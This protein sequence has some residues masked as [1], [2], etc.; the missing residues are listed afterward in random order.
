MA[1]AVRALVV[2]SLIVAAGTA[3]LVA[4]RPDGGEATAALPGGLDGSPAP[5]VRL[6]DARGGMLDSRDLVGRPYLVTFV[7]TSCTDVCPAIGEDVAAALRR[8]PGAAALLVSVDPR[9]DTPRAARRWLAVHR[10]PDRAHYLVGTR[11]Q[12]TP[13]WRDWYVTSDGRLDPA[14][15]AAAIWLVDAQGR[16]RERWPAGAPIDPDALIN[17]R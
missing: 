3:G 16:L 6:P 7:Y 4:A 1:A 11:E 10:L 8:A 15:H 14:N 5:R 2:L 9:G 13:V 12:L 17:A